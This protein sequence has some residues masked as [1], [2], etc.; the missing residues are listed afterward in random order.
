MNNA[1]VDRHA[2]CQPIVGQG[3]LGNSAASMNETVSLSCHDVFKSYSAKAG[4]VLHGVSLEIDQGD[5][6]ALIGANGSGK[7]TLL[8]SLVG[9]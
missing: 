9:V 3:D 5:T 4:M 7:S 2:S 6:V 8:K 1:V